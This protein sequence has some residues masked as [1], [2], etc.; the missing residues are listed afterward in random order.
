MKQALEIAK[1]I[2]EEEMEFISKADYGNES[3]RHKEA[4]RELIF[5]QD[6]LVNSEQSWYPY[7][8]V[9]LTRWECKEGHEREFA[10]CNIIIAL[11]II[12]GKDSSNDPEYMMETISSEY[13]KLPNDLRD[14]VLSLLI[15]A[16]ERCQC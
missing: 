16:E 14:I 2:T 9:E 5:S 15:E 13:D 3:R 11:S 1:S 7:E 4:L 10:I 8:V 12:A 6:C